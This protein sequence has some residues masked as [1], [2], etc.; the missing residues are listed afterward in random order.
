MRMR[1]LGALS[2][3][4]APLAAP[5]AEP[6]R[7]RLPAPLEDGVPLI[8]EAV[9]GAPAGHTDSD[10][11]LHVMEWVAKRTWFHL[12][13]PY[14]RKDFTGPPD[15]RGVRRAASCMEIAATVACAG[16]P[17]RN[18]IVACEIEQR[19][20]PV[21]VLLRSTDAFG[22]LL[23][24]LDLASGTWRARA[25]LVARSMI[26][27]RSHSSPMPEHS[28][29]IPIGEGRFP[30]AAGGWH[31]LRIEARGASVAL[32]LDGAPIGRL[33]DPDPAGGKFGIG[34][35]GTV[36]VRS[37]R[38][39]ELISAAEKARRTACLTAMHDFCRDLDARAGDDVRAKNRIERAGDTLRWT[40]PATGA[41]ATFRASPGRVAA[42]IRAGLYGD[43]TLADGAFPDLAC[44]TADGRTFRPDPAR[45]PAITSDGLAIRIEI[46]LRDPAGAR[47]TARVL[48]RLT[49]Q[50]VWF[51]AVDIDGLDPVRIRAAL[52]IAPAFAARLR[53]KAFLGHNARAGIYVKAI[54]PAA[55][56]IESDGAG[57]LAITTTD[58]RLRFATVIL[59]A[60]PLNRIGFSRRMVHFIRYPEGP[61]EG[62][63][64][65]PSFQEYP[66]DIDLLRFRS[67]GADAMVWHHTWIGN[68]LRDREGFIV[69]D[70]EMRRAMAT[71]HRL[72]MTAI[73]Y[74][75][76]LPGRSALLRID[77]TVPI[78]DSA[79]FDTYGKNWDLQ[80]F[81][82]YNA[83][84]RAQEFIPWM[85][86]YWCREYGLDG[87]YL[88]GGFTRRTRGALAEPLDP[89][90]AGLSVDE[91]I[92]R[93]FCRVREVLRRHGAGFGIETWGG[94][95]W[96]VN[97]FYDCLM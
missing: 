4:L 88:D 87:F 15:L 64:R 93:L 91:L 17:L 21:I 5:A 95:D 85:A 81:T 26:G 38:Q 73:G 22:E 90:D 69:N 58:A 80:D 82:F 96:M 60:Q 16:L 78:D 47:A 8:E 65:R 86:D 40:W 36:A 42:T 79:A 7:F 74:L 10:R 39:W 41:T 29:A 63:R 25:I 18:Q 89:A 43:D 67:Q 56:D 71:T 76:I 61:I 55:T 19:D 23:I 59:P 37:I 45:T 72:G 50:T 34:A 66:T 83:A 27:G 2:L 49:V 46:P 62:W 24:E 3:L 68:D 48:A 77:D 30:P 70:P 57:P 13:R 14:E 54:E 12:G 6:S 1:C 32:D 33:V 35:T 11:H 9:F 97:G 31:T 84:G 92:H 44:Q 20:S 52:A 51:W 75:G 94:L 53:G 28:C